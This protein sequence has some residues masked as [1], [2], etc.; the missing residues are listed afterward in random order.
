MQESSARTE[1]PRGLPDT[2]P[3]GWKAELA[4]R[5]ARTRNGTRLVRR[6]HRGP[7]VVQRPFY[8]EGAEV[9]H[10]L[11]LHPP[12]G[13]VGGDDLGVDVELDA[14]AHA[15]LTTPAATRWYFSRG[16]PARLD[17]RVRVASDAA[18]EWLPQET[19]IYDGAHAAMRTRIDLAE[20][21]RLI[22]GE[23]LGLGRPARGEALCSGRTDFR[24]EIFREEKPLVLER[25]RYDGG[26]P[27]GF[28]G[29][30][31]WATLL[32]APAGEAELAAIR[33][34]LDPTAGVIH[35]ATLQ[36]EVVVIR[37]LAHGTER[38]RAWMAALWEV[39]R[40]RVLGC[41]AVRPRIWDT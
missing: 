2:A 31:A 20:G 23:I 10:T 1:P 19:L 4:L 18:L 34:A 24:F 37:A 25:W 21:S 8:P 38:L 11:L 36:R 14:G 28:Q 32:A 41:V 35:A 26:E 29:Y 15:L 39:L 6:R 17:Q 7:L 33:D 40:P 9:C 13:I 27:C 5:F 3:A 22:A 12:A 30:T 16:I